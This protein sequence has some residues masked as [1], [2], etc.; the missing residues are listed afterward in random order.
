MSGET[1]EKKCQ[2]YD[3]P[4]PTRRARC[5]LCGRVAGPASTPHVCHAD[6]CNVEVPPRMLMCLRHWRMVPRDLQRRVWATYVPG[7]EIRKDPTG[8]YM[9]AQQ[10]AVAAV[11]VKEGR[12]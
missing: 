10:A 3:G 7:Q 1:T 9:E 4:E 2:C 6:G 5:R 8:A 12:R 11:A